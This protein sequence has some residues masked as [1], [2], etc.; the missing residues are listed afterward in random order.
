MNRHT[1]L[2]QY[3]QATRD[4][5]TRHR[6]VQQRYERIFKDD[7]DLPDDV[8]VEEGRIDDIDDDRIDDDRDDDRLDDDS[9][10][11]S[12]DDNSSNNG[13]RN[14]HVVDE[15]ADLLVEGGTPDGEITRAQALR[16][17]MHS[18]RGTALVSRMAAHRKR[19]ALTM[20]RS[21][22]LRSVVKQAGGL[23]PL[24]KRIAAT[25]RGAVTEHELTQLVVDAAKRQHPDL[26]DAQAFTKMF[27]GPAGAVLQKAVAVS[28]AAQVAG[29][30]DD[31][32]DAAA[33]LDQLHRL[34]ERHHHDNP[35]LTPDQSFARVFADPRNAALAQRAH[36]RPAANAKNMF[37][38]PR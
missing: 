10:N 33:A 1:M 8:A 2:A 7:G 27:C 23:M 38:F 22:Q 3:D 5:M 16:W 18:A 19:K 21:E 37:P 4:H 24:C 6:N 32:E 12:G 36:R 34:A 20:N 13:N 11:D 25:G 29:D 26:S 30:D 31:D 28:K 17:L 9:D 14:R 35:E 15:L